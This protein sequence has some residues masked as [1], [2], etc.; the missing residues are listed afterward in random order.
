MRRF[1]WRC[2]DLSKMFFLFPRDF[3][4]FSSDICVCQCGKL[5]YKYK[6]PFCLSCFNL[7][8]RSIVLSFF[9]FHLT[10]LKTLDDHVS[11]SRFICYDK[12]KSVRQKNPSGDAARCSAFQ[13]NWIYQIHLYISFEFALCS[14]SFISNQQ[15]RK[16]TEKRETRE[17]NCY[18]FFELVF[19]LVSSLMV[20][21][22]INVMRDE[23]A[24]NCQFVEVRKYSIFWKILKPWNF[25]DVSFINF[26][27][28]LRKLPKFTQ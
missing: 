4:I 1:S 22:V 5:A 25:P 7:H 6:F 15:A 23:T 27:V 26:P 3:H 16:V 2:L 18:F 21:I 9:T 13:L 14:R 12:W 19:H 28:Q 8:K 20:I 11:V 24:A 10:S 17:T